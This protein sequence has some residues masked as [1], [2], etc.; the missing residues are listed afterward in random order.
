VVISSIRLSST[1]QIVEVFQI[2]MQNYTNKI[3]LLTDPSIKL[4]GN[5]ILYYYS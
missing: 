3:V 1:F 4:Q 2:L 5:V